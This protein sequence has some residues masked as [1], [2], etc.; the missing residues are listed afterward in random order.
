VN[1]L[2]IGVNALYLIPGEVG[3]T[4]I[5]L[6]SLLAALGEMDRRNRYFV[7]ANRETQPDLVPDAENF[8]FV[9]EPVN[10]RSR[11][12]R[13]IWEQTGLVLGAA[14]LKL[15][16][17][18]NPGFTA[19]VLCPCPQV[20]VFH[21][22]RFK[23]HPQFTRWLDLPVYRILLYLSARVSRHL[24]AD[25]E[26][27]AADVRRHYP[28]AASKMN[29]AMLGVDEA[30]FAVGRR[31]DPAKFFLTV[32]SLHPHKNLGRLLTAFVRFR[33][34]HPDFRLVI[35]GMP[36]D[37]VKAL[38][39]LHRSL[40][41]GDA[42][43][44]A[45]WIPR[46]DVYDLF[47]RAWAFVYPTLFEGFGLPLVEAM[48][49]GVPTT[50]SRIEPLVQIAAGGALLFD[51]Q[52]EDELTSAMIRIADDEPLRNSLSR[53]GGRRARSFSWAATADKTL[54]ALTKAAGDDH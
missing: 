33:A 6:R 15:N 42:V 25:S 47:A 8:I 34:S 35:C 43:V 14:R 51:P 29:V 4:E 27:T 49:A 3:G 39:E 9:Q 13:L 38:H 21:D 24:I 45:G 12:A 20:T 11:P 26:A 52:S 41:L 1:G 50:C 53:E 30:F 10:A 22:L 2:R 16:V 18:L 36:G 54:T 40:E 17:M 19:P 28:F 7:F 44:F 46:E 37:D 23:R 48:A 32:S 31:R 5:Y